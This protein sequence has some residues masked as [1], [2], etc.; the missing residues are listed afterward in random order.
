MSTPSPTRSRLDRD[1]VLAAAEEVLAEVG[2]ADLTM[3]AVAAR[4]GIRVPSLYHHLAGLDDLRSG[5]Q[6]RAMATLSAELRTAAMGRSGVAGLVALARVQ[7]GYALAHRESYL[8]ATT[9]PLD[10]AAYFAA[11]TPGLEAFLAVIG[12]PLHDPA[13]IPAAVSCFSAFH[14][15]IALECAGYFDDSVAPETVFESVATAVA[16]EVCG[17]SG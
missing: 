4:L 3:A 8:G 10:R 5:L 1:A 11:A 16:R 15:P 13:A 6:V 12:L 14:G 17:E 7:R 9:E 2:W